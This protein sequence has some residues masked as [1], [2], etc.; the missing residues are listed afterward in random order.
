MFSKHTSLEFSKKCDINEVN[1]QR[2]RYLFEA[3]GASGGSG[4]DSKGNT[5]KGMGGYVSGMIKI[6]SPTKLLI[7][8]GGEGSSSNKSYNTFP[9]GCNGGGAGGKSESDTKCSGS[10]GGGATD[11]RLLDGEWSD[12][13]SLMS[14]II[15]AGG[16]GGS[17]YHGVRDLYYYGGSG[18]GLVGT[19]AS[20]GAK[21]ASQNGP[22]LQPVSGSFGYGGNVIQ[23]VEKDGCGGC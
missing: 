5:G 20:S 1:L 8:V 13:N 7:I 4:I 22:G 19:D 6:S 9:G 21:G 10:G 18:G 12:F 14:R 23:Q 17:S 11:I 15:V 3:W 2:G 16:G